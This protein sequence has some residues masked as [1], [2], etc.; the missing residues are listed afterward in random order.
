M[1]REKRNQLAV[2][3]MKSY[4]LALLGKPISMGPLSTAY[5]VSVLH[6]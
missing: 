5:Y 4:R 3:K 6:R 2:Q 1:R